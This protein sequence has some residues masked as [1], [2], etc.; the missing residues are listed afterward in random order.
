MSVDQHKASLEKQ[1]RYA[2]RR[3][4]ELIIPRAQHNKYRNSFLIRGLCNYQSL[5]AELKTIEKLGQF[6]K[7]CKLKLNNKNDK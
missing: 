7:A 6:V 3:K 1:H 4:Q 2:T 5:P